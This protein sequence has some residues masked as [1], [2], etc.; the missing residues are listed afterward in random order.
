[1][2]QGD[3]EQLVLVPD[4]G[5]VAQQCSATRLPCFD[6]FV[7]KKNE[8]QPLKLTRNDKKHD[9]NRQLRTPIDNKMEVINKS[10]KKQTV[11]SESVAH[12][13]KPPLTKRGKRVKENGLAAGRE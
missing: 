7:E 5:A 13:S 12:E 8:R 6:P 9:E 3:L 10:V 1:M 2:L 4:P 11:Y